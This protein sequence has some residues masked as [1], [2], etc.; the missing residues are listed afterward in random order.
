MD[1]EEWILAEPGP[2]SKTAPP[3]TQSAPV[4]TPADTSGRP[5]VFGVDARAIPLS[6]GGGSLLEQGID[7]ALL[8]TPRSDEPFAVRAPRGAIGAGRHFVLRCAGLERKRGALVRATAVSEMGIA[9]DLVTAEMVQSSDTGLPGQPPDASS[10]PAARSH[11]PIQ[12]AVRPQQETLLERDAERARA[13]RHASASAVQIDGVSTI[14]TDVS[15]TLLTPVQMGEVVKIVAP[16]G[17]LP[18][19]SYFALRYFDATGAKRAIVRAEAVHAQAGMLDEIDVALVRLPTPA[20]ERQ[21]YRAP[22]E[23]YFSAEVRGRNGGRTVRGRISDLSAGGIGFRITSNLAPGEMLRIT[24]PALS[25]LDGAELLVVRR[26]PR[27]LHRYGARFVEANRGAATLSTI[28]GLEHAE[29]EH[30]RRIQIQEIRR[31]RGATAAP[32]TA[33]DIHALRN[34]RMRTRDHES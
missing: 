15:T 17:E 5:R 10:S 25:D 19:G 18:E 16:R 21:S 4:A 32:L 12:P 1:S 27:D 8:M 3:A 34:R 28:L 24:D 29:R 11:P 7:V 31:T 23:C 26:D 30:R 2:R 14:G 13:R 9:F 22:F 6:I 33:A 20:E